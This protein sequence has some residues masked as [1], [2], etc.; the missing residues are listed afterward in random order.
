MKVTVRMR[1]NP[2]ERGV[3]ALERTLAETIDAC[4]ELLAASRKLKRS[5]PAS[6]AY[7]DQLPNLAVCATVLKAKTESIEREIDQIE[8]TLPD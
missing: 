2:T 8:D 6:E 4:E 1:G 3:A 7:L 5:K